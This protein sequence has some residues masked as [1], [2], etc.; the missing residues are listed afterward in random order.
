MKAILR[1]LA[2]RIIS[3]EKMVFEFHNP[4]IGRIVSNAKSQRSVGVKMH[5]VVP[6]DPDHP[7]WVALLKTH[8]DLLLPE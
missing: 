4:T 3:G 5:V 6:V 7:F 1:E 2:N 8:P